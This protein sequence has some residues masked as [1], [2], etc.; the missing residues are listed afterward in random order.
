MQVHWGWCMLNV[1]AFTIY[2]RVCYKAGEKRKRQIKEKKGNSEWPG[3]RCAAGVGGGGGGMGRQR[4]FDDS[5]GME[6]KGGETV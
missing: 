4:G 2:V 5:W 1:P 6:R 3:E